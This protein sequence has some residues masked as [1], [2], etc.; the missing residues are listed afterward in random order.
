MKLASIEKRPAH[1]LRA[2]E[3]L[4]QRDNHDGAAKDLLHDLAGI[5]VLV[6]KKFTNE[7]TA[8]GLQ[9]AFYLTTGCV[10][11]GIALAEAPDACT[12][13][14]HHGAEHVFQMGFRHIKALAEL[15]GQTMVTDFDR[16]PYVQ[17]RNIKALFSQLCRAEP[18]SSW[19]GDRDYRD[20][21]QIREDNLSIIECAKWL[22][23]NH[24]AGPIT[25]SDLDASAVISIAVIFAISGRGLIVARTGQKDIEELIRTTRKNKPEIESNW[26][27]FLKKIPPRF[28][29]LISARMD[30]YRDTIIRKIQSKTAIKTVVTEIQNYHAGIEQDVEYD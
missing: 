22:R 17:Q 15:P 28:H 30:E 10:S 6:A 13:L 8:D 19:N 11:L 1:L 23:K 12:F 3:T 5:T 24:Y 14:L 18:D 2:I 26:G 20:E 25:D 7:R 21:L 16:D 4:V 29:P 9:E 27:A